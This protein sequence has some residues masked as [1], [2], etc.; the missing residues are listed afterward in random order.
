MEV[1]NGELF[2]NVELTGKFSESDKDYK[3]HENTSLY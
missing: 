1:E 3:V 2:S